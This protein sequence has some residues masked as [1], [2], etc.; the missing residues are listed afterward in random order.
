MMQRKQI[1]KTKTMRCD[2]TRRDVRVTDESTAL[3]NDGIVQLNSPV[4]SWCNNMDFRCNSACQ[5]RG[6]EIDPTRAA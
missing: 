6:G 2:M 5:Y 4:I 3:I 1:T